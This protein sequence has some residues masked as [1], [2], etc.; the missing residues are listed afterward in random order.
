MNNDYYLWDRGEWV[1]LS[2]EPERALGFGRDYFADIFRAM[3][4]NGVLHGISFFLSAEAPSS[5]PVYGG[6]VVLVIGGDEHYRYF[7]YFND[8]LAVLRC[9]GPLPHYLDGPPTT[10]LKLSAVVLWLWRCVNVL[11]DLWGVSRFNPKAIRNIFRKVLHV[12]LG[13]F[14][15]FHPPDVG[16]ECRTIDCAFLG[17]IDR[18]QHSGW[19]LYN[20]ITP[21]KI[22]ARQKMVEMLKSHLSRRPEIRGVFS[23]TSNFGDSISRQETYA[24]TLSQCKISLCP[25]GSNYETYRYYESLKA[26]CV[27]ISEAIPDAW[28]YK[29]HPAVVIGDWS[30]APRIVDRLL[31]DPA[32][33]IRMSEAARSFWQSHLS[34]G[35]VAAKIE[36]FLGHLISSRGSKHAVDKG[37]RGTAVPLFNDAANNSTGEDARAE[38]GF[39]HRSR[40]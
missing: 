2:L 32:G 19:S 34:E 17:S 39:A 16:L 13:C 27:V 8:I 23:V 22:L 4:T 11:R 9:Y 21:P 28:F 24:E 5:L 15:E 12:P 18:P 6:A 35:V 31:A 25:R 26:G 20:M 40:R 38:A 30:E 33:M 29:D 36:K 7:P 14:G 10:W 1:A 3:E 37:A